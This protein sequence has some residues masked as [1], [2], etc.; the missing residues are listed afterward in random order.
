MQYNLER[1]N[2]EY[3]LKIDRVFFPAADMTLSRQSM[4]MMKPRVANMA[5]ASHD[6]MRSKPTVKTNKE[7]TRMKRYSKNKSILESMRDVE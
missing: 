3:H 2:K 7:A 1:K 5:A 6:S 4:A